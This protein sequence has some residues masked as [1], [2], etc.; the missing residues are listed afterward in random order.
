M[1]DYSSLKFAAVLGLCLTSSFT[2]SVA[3]ELHDAVRNGELSEVSKALEAAEDVNETDYLLGTPL[4]LATVSGIADIA[5]LLLEGG[6]DIDAR[7]ENN[8]R[9]A[10][11]LASELGNL[12]VVQLLLVEGADFRYRDATEQEAI[13]LASAGGHSSV[14]SILLEAG[15]DIESNGTF[16][17]LT[18]LMI[19]SQNGDISLVRFLLN[20]GADPNAVSDIGMNAFSLAATLSSYR[21]VGG[22]ALM[23]LLIAEGANTTQ[24]NDTGLT[25]LQWARERGTRDYNEI[26]EV[27]I[28][29]C[30]EE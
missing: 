16:E 5:S 28:G 13:H 29:L 18:P 30:V 27:L 14:I 21:N 9:T 12:E 17:V 8:A 20:E 3:S 6:L 24:A 23:R 11:Q 2:G 15:A 10:L 1:S 25:P 19:A 26:A 22:D 4:H 7:S